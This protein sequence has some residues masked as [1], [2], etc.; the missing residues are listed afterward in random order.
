MFSRL[1]S[2]RR[3]GH[4]LLVSFGNLSSKRGTGY[5][6]H[7]Q[8]SG[9]HNH[10]KDPGVV[11]QCRGACDPNVESDQWTRGVQN[12]FSRLSWPLKPPVLQMVIRQS[13]FRVTSDSSYLGLRWE[14]E[15]NRW[16]A[17]Q[18]G[19]KIWIPW[20]TRRV[21]FRLWHLKRC[22]GVRKGPVRRRTR[23]SEVS[24]GQ[25]QKSLCKALSAGA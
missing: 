10:V 3:A 8:T 18:A 15:L 19:H 17:S 6:W 9:L 20:S 2:R 7:G 24:H 16:A 5:S 1:V 13:S 14:Q 21:Q 12:W 22:M 25:F 23:K 4:P 11:H